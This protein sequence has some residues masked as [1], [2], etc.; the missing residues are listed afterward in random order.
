MNTRDPWSVIQCAR[1]PRRPTAQ[2]VIKHLAPD[3]IELRGDRRFGDDRAIRG[4]IGSING[5][6]MTI[7]SEEKGKTLEE[8]IE[9]WVGMPHPEGYR[10]IERLV[11]QADKF[12]RPVLFLIDTPGAYPGVE[13]ESRGQA[14][15]IASLIKYLFQVSV[16]I[17]AV[18]L[19]E[20]GSGGALAIGISDYLMMFENAFYSILSP[21]GY[22]AILYKDATL[23]KDKVAEMKLT[24]QDLL[25]Y[26][27]ID[28]IIPEGE[29]WWHETIIP[30]IEC[31]R[32]SI[33]KQLGILL[34][35][36]PEERLNRRL[37]RYRDI[38]KYKEE[39]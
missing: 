34:D 14:E 16:P 12:H 27:I 1:H 4:G 9:N 39:S 3:F 30:P 23:A 28:E 6:V 36:K 13:A 22:A 8:K 38:G 11:R 37:K 26:H 5:V 2:T 21:E 17:I 24:A 25:A 35:I 15:A 31:L 20:G 10:K 7:I 18:V 19:S 32:E 29:L 33:G